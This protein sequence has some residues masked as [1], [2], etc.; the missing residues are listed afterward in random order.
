MSIQVIGQGSNTTVAAVYSNCFKQLNSTI[1]H[2]DLAKLPVG[3]L[4]RFSIQK[5]RYIL[6][7]ESVGLVHRDSKEEQIPDCMLGDSTQQFKL[8]RILE[9]FYLDLKFLQD[10][11]LDYGLLQI[12]TPTEQAPQALK[13]FDQIFERFI[14]RLTTQSQ[15][16]QISGP[17][18]VI[19]DPEY[20]T[21]TIFRK[22]L[23]LVDALEE[24]TAA[25]EPIEAQHARIKAEIMSISDLEN[26]RLIRDAAN[27]WYPYLYESAV[28]RLAAISGLTEGMFPL[29]WTDSIAT[30]MRGQSNHTSDYSIMG[31][32]TTTFRDNLLRGIAIARSA[33]PTFRLGRPSR[34]LHAH[35]EETAEEETAEEE[36]PA[37]LK[38]AAEVERHKIVLLGEQCVGKTALALM[39]SFS[40]NILSHP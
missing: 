10:T 18:W 26:L 2:L 3:V 7:G 29:T 24:I 28:D 37:I 1:A 23:V 16:D 8:S 34:Q 38:K 31:P 20:F 22:L 19:D 32:S 39:V 6:W 36:S 21:A 9:K 17:K 11:G 14:E 4:S 40:L 35:N 13:I 33:V 12:T 25:I 15:E 27:G 5:L 30:T